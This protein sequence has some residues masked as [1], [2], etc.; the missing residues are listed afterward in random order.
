MNPAAF[1]FGLASVVAAL[2][3][4]FIFSSA[5]SAI[6]EIAAMVCGLSSA[7]FGVGSVVVFH[8]HRLPDRIARAIAEGGSD[9]WHAPPDT[10][11]RQDNDFSA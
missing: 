8:L 5:K 6:H 10:G 1:L 9:A 3:S 7:V 4:I 11:A 2:A